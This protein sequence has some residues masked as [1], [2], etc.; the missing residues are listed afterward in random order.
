MSSGTRRHRRVS[1]SSHFASSYFSQIFTGSTYFESEYGGLTDS[2]TGASRRRE[3]SRSHQTAHVIKR[4]SLLTG[5]LIELYTPRASLAPYSHHMHH[6]HRYSRQSSVPRTGPASIT[7]ARP[8]YISPSASPHSQLSIH[9]QITARQQSSSPQ[10]LRPSRSPSP[11]SFVPVTS[12][13]TTRHSLRPCYS[14]P[15]L[16]VP[17]HRLTTANI[18]PTETLVEETSLAAAAAVH[19][20]VKKSLYTIQRQNAIAS[21][22]DSEQSPTSPKSNLSAATRRTMLKETTIE[23]T[24]GPV[25]LKR[26][27]SS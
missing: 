19:Q 4:N 15:R 10:I 14:A 13:T 1:T 8:L 21:T 7:P 6:Y 22:D 23:S 12:A 3:S 26:S 18:K 17:L 5:E 9:S 27:N 16:H 25:W 24:G 20:P 11:Y 2:L